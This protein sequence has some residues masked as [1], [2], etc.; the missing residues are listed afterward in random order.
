MSLNTIRLSNVVFTGEPI[1][2]SEMITSV[3]DVPPRISGPYD[4][5]PVV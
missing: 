1:G 3:R 5:S 2:A 4:G